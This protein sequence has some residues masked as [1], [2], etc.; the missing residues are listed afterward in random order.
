MWVQASNPLFYFQYI[1][2]ILGPWDKW[3]SDLAYYIEDCRMSTLIWKLHKNINFNRD[4]QIFA[5][6]LQCMH[7]IGIC[8]RE[9]AFVKCTS[10]N[11]D[12]WVTPLFCK[13]DWVIEFIN[14]HI[15][16]NKSMY[17]SNIMLPKYRILSRLCFKYYKLSSKVLFTYEYTWQIFCLRL[18]CLVNRL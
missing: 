18:L 17:F 5:S 14:I 1:K 15:R 2:I 11:I 7:C 3:P 10:A 12:E 4:I 13:E 8:G 6:I 9:E 16:L